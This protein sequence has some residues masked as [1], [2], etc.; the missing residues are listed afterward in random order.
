MMYQL[1]GD[2]VAHGAFVSG[3]GEMFSQTVNWEHVG[4]NIP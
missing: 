2:A 3:T 1:Q 4:S